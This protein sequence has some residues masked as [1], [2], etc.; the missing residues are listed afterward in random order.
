MPFND[1][2]RAWMKGIIAA[3]G[4]KAGGGVHGATRGHPQPPPSDDDDETPPPTP[5]ALP[6]EKHSGPAKKQKGVVDME[7]MV[8]D[9]HAD[10]PEDRQALKDAKGQALKDFNDE[11]DKSTALIES[12]AMRSGP[13]MA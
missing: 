10:S 4:S 12:A 6:E 9:P 7:P 11:A 3:K 5:M 1:A 13:I 2:Q 8:L